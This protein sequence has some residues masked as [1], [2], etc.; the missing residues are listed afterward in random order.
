MMFLF[1]VSHI[2]LKK[3]DLFCTFL[4]FKDSCDIVAIS[5]KIH[6]FY[7]L[8]YLLNSPLQ[9]QNDEM[10]FSCIPKLWPMY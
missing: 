6:S 4:P 3:M 7:S 5:S 1:F 10:I 2:T 9:K 8:L